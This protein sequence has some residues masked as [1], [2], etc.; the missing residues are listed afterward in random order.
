MQTERL[1]PRRP[2]R[3][4]GKQAGRQ[5]AEKQ[6]GIKLPCGQAGKKAW[7]LE[8]RRKDKQTYGQ[9]SLW[10]G[11]ESDLR[12]TTKCDPNH[13]RDNYEFGHTEIWSKAQDMFNQP[14]SKHHNSGFD[15]RVNPWFIKSPDVCDLTQ[16]EV[17]L[18]AP[19]PLFQNLSETLFLSVPKLFRSGKKNCHFIFRRNF[20]FSTRISDIIKFEDPELDFE[21]ILKKKSA[22]F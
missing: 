16:A 4:V 7:G 20:F 17:K 9:K 12:S 10:G 13:I 14:A 22:N 11:F 6:L 1:E 3:Q 2:S 21:S 8:G 5:H 19:N 15:F 18:S